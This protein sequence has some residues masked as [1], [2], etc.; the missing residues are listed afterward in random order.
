MK[1]KLFHINIVLFD[2]SETIK[3][4]HYQN[5]KKRTHIII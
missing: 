4:K 1:K 2:E 3:R 5:K